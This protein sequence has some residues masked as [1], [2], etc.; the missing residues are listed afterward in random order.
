MDGVRKEQ[1]TVRGK[2]KQLDDAL[3]VIDKDIASLQ[4]ELAVITEKRDKARES[5][6]QFRKQRDDGVCFLCR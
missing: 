4:D 5:I 1:Q 6:Q 2:I 3:K